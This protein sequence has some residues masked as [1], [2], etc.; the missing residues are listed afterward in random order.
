MDD[1]DK[2][3]PLLA[4]LCREMENLWLITGYKSDSQPFPKVLVTTSAESG[5]AAPLTPH[6][7][8]RGAAGVKV[9][10]SKSGSTDIRDLTAELISDSILDPPDWRIKYMKE[11]ETGLRELVRSH[12]DALF[13]EFKIVP[14]LIERISETLGFKHFNPEE[15]AAHINSKGDRYTRIENTL[16]LSRVLS[17]ELSVEGFNPS[18]K[19]PVGEWN[20]IASRAAEK[21]YSVANRLVN[22]YEVIVFLN[23]PMV[24]GE[25]PAPLATVESHGEKHELSIGYATDELLT[26]LHRSDDNAQLERINTAVRFPFVVSV[27]APVE[28]YLRVYPVGA[29]I[30]ERV[31]DCLRLIRDQDIGVMALEV[32]TTG[33]FMPDIRKTY[34]VFYNSQLAPFVP[35]RFSFE[36]EPAPPLAQGEIDQLRKLLFFYSEVPNTKG[37]SVALRRF[38]S[39]CERY[40]PS[41]PERLLD[42]AVSFEAVFLND[43]ENKELRYR[44]ALRVARFLGK[45]L[46]ERVSIFET[47]KSLY[48]YRSKIAHGETLDDMKTGDAE[49]VRGVLARAPRILKDSLASMI[50]GNGPKGLVKEALGKWWR[51]LEL[52]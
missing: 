46:E 38:R 6:N 44:L 34:E 36:I 17:A 50:L 41:D 31:V 16:F 10:V 49:K 3:Q 45:T 2:I 5:I 37:L 4:A 1:N 27:N 43:N 25:S 21:I 8:M 33:T 47:V 11:E 30:A 26:K 51:D 19:T 32:F 22:E 52:S 15:L 35:K 42:I 23:A 7:L 14:N 12:A 40:Y 48:D 9:S 24:E 20:E 39:S 13:A 29:G 18:Q 28:S